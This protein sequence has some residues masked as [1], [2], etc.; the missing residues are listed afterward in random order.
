M[1]PQGYGSRGLSP[2]PFSENR[3][4]SMPNYRPQSSGGYQNYNQQPL[5]RSY[6]RPNQNYN[7]QPQR[8]NLSHS[9]VSVASSHASHLSN[10]MNEPDVFPEELVFLLRNEENNIN[11]LKEKIEKEKARVENDFAVF[12]AEINH[13]LEDVKIS[14]QAELDLTYKSY[15]TKYAELKG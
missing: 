4:P 1:F 5:N 8:N 7:F 11:N 13:I 15:I 12:R 10:L 6:G 9:K 14:I 3:P 2:S